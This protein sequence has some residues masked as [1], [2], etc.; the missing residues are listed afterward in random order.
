MH[1]KFLNTC[2]PRARHA[3]SKSDVGCQIRAGGHVDV[4]QEANE[5]GFGINDPHESVLSS[6]EK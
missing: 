1:A 3:E 6:A 5:L 4:V 2:H